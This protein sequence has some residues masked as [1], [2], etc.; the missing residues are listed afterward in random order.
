MQY[1]L[2][3]GNSE[4]LQQDLDEALKD[5]SALEIIEKHLMDGMNE[6]GVLFGAGKMF[7]PQV[8]KSARTM[9]QAV[10]YLKQYLETS[11]SKKKA[12]K[13]VLATV[14]G[15]VHD[16]G[17][18]ILGLI[19]TCNNFEVV[20]LGVM[21][22]CSDILK[23]AQEENADIVALS[24]L[25]TPS[26]EEM[27]IVAEQMEKAGFTLPAIMIGG[28]TTSKLHTALKIAPKYNGIVAHTE[29]AS[30]AVVVAQ[31]IISKDKVFIDNLKAEQKKLFDE[32]QNG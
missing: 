15:D 1:A 12:G 8:V 11:N 29:D 24:G 19:L 6:I 13:I 18:N 30:Q 28:A 4:Y 3:K 17:K 22:N 14:K 2:I 27:V 26:L 10:D 32:Y 5:F 7:L 23:S 20:D 25:I 21:V 31:K 16:I 9:K